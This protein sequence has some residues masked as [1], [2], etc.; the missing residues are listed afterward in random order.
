[1]AEMKKTRQQ[2]VAKIPEKKEIKEKAGYRPRVVVKFRDTVEL[3][4]EDGAEKYVE[5]YEVGPWGRLAK[6]FPG[7]TLRRLFTAANAEQ[8]QSLVK[9]AT[10]NDRTF[11]PPDL[12]SYFIVDCPVGVR[13]EVLVKE[14]MSW[15]SVQTSYFDPPGS[16]PLV[17]PDDDPRYTSQGYLDPAPD[18]IDAE[19]AWPRAGGIGFTGGD[20]A[21]IR[22]I[23][24]EQ[25][26]TLN[27]ED[28]NAHSASLLHGTLANSSRYH[29][30]AVLGEVCAVDNTIGCVGI[31]PK[32][33]SVNVVS[34]YGSSRP[35]AILAAITN[36][37]F[38][39]I[40]LLEAQLDP[41]GTNVTWYPIEILDAEF[42][43]IRLATALG[44][45]VVEAG[46]NGNYS[47]NVGNDL[48]SYTDAAGHH[49]LN[50]GSAEFRDSGAII[51]GAG[52][53]ASP[54]IRMY[55]SNYGS[56]VDCYAWGENV[57]S[58]YSNNVGSTTL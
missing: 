38:G 46:G 27:H 48:D 25:G 47:T 50:R 18:G 51:V 8:I 16:D 9:R 35:D 58:C 49:I 45:V 12:L 31:A 30:T 41:Y 39:D 20:G 11:C 34:Y 37:S 36:L 1:M 57:N 33:T 17:N 22:F 3:P 56:R 23:D 32:I 24:M 44:I 2:V 40:L 29:G 21:G 15:Q 14:F 55:Y 13:P 42:D 19:F 52:S 26:W 53:S 4:Y 5:Q 28:L 7:I 10:E 54:H 43:A 6:E